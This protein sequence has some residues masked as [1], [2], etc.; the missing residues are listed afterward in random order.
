[1]S[2]PLGGG[3]CPRIPG[4]T[5]GAAL[6]CG[7]TIRLRSRAGSCDGEF[8]DAVEDRPLAGAF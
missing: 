8:E 5:G 7:L 6:G 4:G 3:P 1:M 2:A